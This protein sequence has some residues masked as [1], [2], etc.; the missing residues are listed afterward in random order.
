MKENYSFSKLSS[1]NGCK[2]GYLLNYIKC[3]EACSSFNREEQCCE[4]AL[5]DFDPLSSPI[6]RTHCPFFTKYVN[7]ENA[8][9]QYGTMVHGILEEYERGDLAEWELVDCFKERF[10]KEITKDFPWNAYVDSERVILQRW[11]SLL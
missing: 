1:F 11:C 3:C 2:Y 8:F 6:E 7:E 9:S 10:E 5:A 4:H